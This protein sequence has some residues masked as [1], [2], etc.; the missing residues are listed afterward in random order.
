M[1]AVTTDTHKTNI[2]EFQNDTT[3]INAFV[4][5]LNAITDEQSLP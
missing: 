2:F 5:A 1:Q 4:A 3:L